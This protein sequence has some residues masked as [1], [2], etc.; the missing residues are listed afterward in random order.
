MH[1]ER[2][3]TRAN[4]NTS[5]L[6]TGWSAA[7]KRCGSPYR[8]LSV[9]QMWC[10]DDCRFLAY[11]GGGHPDE[12]WEWSGNKNNQGYGVFTGHG[13]RVLGAHREAYR[14]AF[15]DVPLNLC[16]MHRC[17]NRLCVNPSHLQAGTWGDNNRDRSRKGRSGRR[18]YTEHQRQEYSRRFRGVGNQNAK[19][20][21]ERARAIKYGHRDLS[22]SK[23]A[24]MYGV[25]ESVAG[26][27]RTG[28]SW[29]HV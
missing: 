7:C 25:S 8:A 5:G 6:G 13:R 23:V 18:E 28:R 1:K 3:M 2:R 10:S 17:D 21:D 11:Q 19:L 26:H 14:R 24:K 4:L 29:K 9:K 12:C 27:I 20:D 16:I 15:G 22:A